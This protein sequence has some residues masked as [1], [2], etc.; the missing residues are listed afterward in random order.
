MSELQQNAYPQAWRDY[1]AD[2]DPR[3]QLM[4]LKGRDYLTV[5]DRMRWFVRDQRAL[6]VAGLARMPYIVRADLVEHNP[7]EGYAH[8]ACYVR[9]VLGNEVT[10]YGSERVKDFGDY[11]EKASTKAL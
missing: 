7:Q 1:D 10:M 11:A 4:Q 6:I 5:Q 9:D 2:F 8:F 3:G